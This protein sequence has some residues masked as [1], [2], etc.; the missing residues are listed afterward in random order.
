MKK[1][2]ALMM[3]AAMFLCFAG[4]GGDNSKSDSDYVKEK[5]TLI[6]GITDYAP[7]DYQENGSDEW[8]G[9]DA[10][11]A[12]AFAKE[13]GVKVK[14]VEIN[15]DNKTFEL[16]GKSI[17]C[18]WNG[19][20]L[21][22]GVK[23]AMATSNPYSKN[24]QVVVVPKDKADQYNSKEAIKDLN[25]AVEGGSAGESV[26]DALSF[27]KVPVTS[28]ADAVK[29]VA[30]GT[31]D[32][33][34]IDLL[35]AGAVIGEGTSYE[36]LTYTISLSDEEEQFGVGFRKNSDLVEKLNAFFVKCYQDGSMQEIAKTYGVQEALIEQ[37]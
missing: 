11:M 1:L 16:D 9:F 3:T 4:C 30:S 36:N 2:L 17:D 18:V 34:V 29:E 12:K 10:D 37:K 14:F 27:K 22:D 19:M 33:A 13:L 35:M 15:W 21:S 32:A 28:Q 31:S 24:K 7:M 23:K 6:V 20:T 5:G 26:V 25:F 8:I